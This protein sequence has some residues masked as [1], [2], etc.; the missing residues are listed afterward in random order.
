M[1]E[2]NAPSL[3]NKMNHLLISYNCLVS[4]IFLIIC[5]YS[6]SHHF[7]SASWC[8]HWELLGYII[9]Q[10]AIFTCSFTKYVNVMLINKSSLYL[11]LLNLFLLICLT[12]GMSHFCWILQITRR[13]GILIYYFTLRKWI[14][15]FYQVVH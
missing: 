9:T 2:I 12:L 3:V 6:L 4:T 11:E 14:K 10:Q 5:Y 1:W 15:F 7:L 13:P 8:S